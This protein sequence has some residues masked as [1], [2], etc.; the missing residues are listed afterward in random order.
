[1]AL[2]TPKNVKAKAY[3]VRVWNPTIANLTLM[4]LGSSAP[5]ILLSVIELFGNRMYAGELGPSTIV[6]SAAFNLLMILAICVVCIPDGASRRIKA[7][8]AAAAAQPRPRALLAS[9][10]VRLA[11]ARAAGRSGALARARHRLIGCRAPVSARAGPDGVRVHRLRVRL[12]VR[13]A[14]GRAAGALARHDRAVGGA[15]HLPLLPAAGGVRVP[16][17]HPVLRPRRLQ[18]AQAGRAGGRARRRRR[19]RGLQ[20]PPG[21]GRARRPPDQERAGARARAFLL[22]SLL[23]PPPL[24]SSCLRPCAVSPLPIASPPAPL[25]ARTPSHHP[26]SA[27]PHQP[28]GEDVPTDVLGELVSLRLAA[29]QPRS[30]AYYRVQATRGLTAGK[31][32]DDAVPKPSELSTATKKFGSLMHLDIETF[33]QVVIPPPLPSPSSPSSPSLPSLPDPPPSPLPPTHHRMPMHL[34]RATQPLRLRRRAAHW[35]TTA[36]RTCGSRRVPNRASRATERSA[37]ARRRGCAPRRARRG[38]WRRCRRARPRRRARRRC[39]SSRMPRRLWSSIRRL[40]DQIRSA[41]PRALPQQAQPAAHAFLPPPTSSAPFL[42]DAQQVPD[43]LCARV[44]RHGDADDPPHRQRQLQVLRQ[45]Q[46]RRRHG[47][48]GR[49]LRRLRRRDRVW[50][51]ADAGD[52]RHRHHRRQPLRA[53]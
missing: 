52:H 41:L 34:R 35:S 25:V 15:R 42:R 40:A 27:S 19:R 7:R 36:A 11:A 21:A 17:R 14:R 13:L 29:M 8:A 32:L 26:Q 24:T 50:R 18:E 12:R 49:R 37:R 6:G 23:L 20:A 51:R 31:P 28:Q 48:G 9:R 39:S 44:G 16:A 5:E 4:A 22:S 53:E 38:R 43:V 45:V 1:M 10:R 30:R 33:A 46:D 47:D 2:P 3:Y